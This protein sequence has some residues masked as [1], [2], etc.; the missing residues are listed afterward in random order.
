MKTA[1]VPGVP[2]AFVDQLREQGIEELYPPQAEA[3]EAGVTDGQSLVASVPTASGKTLVAQLAM[4]SAVQRGGKALYIV[5]L[6]AL[7]SEKREEF[8]AFEPYGVSIG[9]ATGNYEDTGEWLAEKDV[10]VATSE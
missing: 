6:R 3:V 10:I 9:V 7:A 8:E 4:L 1:D 2:S 5:P